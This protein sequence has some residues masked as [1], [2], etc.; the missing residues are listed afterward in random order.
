MRL[1]IVSSRH[2]TYR[3]YYTTKKYRSCGYHHH[4]YTVTEQRAAYN[5]YTA[6]G[7]NQKLRLEDNCRRFGISVGWMG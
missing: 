1:K 5:E 6:D 4:Q 7:W 3:S 2:P